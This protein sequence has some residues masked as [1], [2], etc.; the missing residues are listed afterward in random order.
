MPPVYEKPRDLYRVTDEKSLTR[1]DGCG[2]FDTTFNYHI[3]WDEWVN[4]ESLNK[5]LNWKYRFDVSKGTH[6]P[7]LIISTTIDGQQAYE[8]A[9]R[10][11]A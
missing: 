10:R 1:I 7:P 5:R 4:A 6:D 2:T 8:E 3:M 11:R 9:A